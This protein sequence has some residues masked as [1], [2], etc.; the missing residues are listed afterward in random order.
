MQG[1]VAI[2]T[3]GNTGIGKATVEGLTRQGATV[4]LACRDLDKGNAAADEV[5]SR[6]PAANVRVMRLDLASLD[7]VR[8]FADAFARAFARLDVLIEN[9]GVS[10]ATRQLTK[11]GFEMD[12]GVNHLGHFLLVDLLLPLLKASVPSRI[13][14]VS[15]SV[16]TG[17]KLDFDDLQGEKSWSVFGA[18][19][20]SKLANMLFVHALAKRLHDTGVVVNA[21]H[22]GVVASELARDLPAPF[23]LLARLFFSS[24][25]KGART[26]LYVATAAETG[27]VS[28]K[29]FADS[30]IAAPA[31][32]AVDDAIAHRLWVE[33]E[34]M[35][36]NN[37][38]A[39]IHLG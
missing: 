16:H 8:V 31:P 23:R 34:K 12:F 13:V 32:H 11:D 22:P 3:G 36:A 19:G 10:T 7:S 18:Y 25:A 27:K 30:K 28:G 9:A 35:V 37:A 26:S 15:S 38:A 33:S 20:R 24:T 17:A 21:V 5:C 2:V 14:V 4:V 1:K 39:T 6:V 29:Y